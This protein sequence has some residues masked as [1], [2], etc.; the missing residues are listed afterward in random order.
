VRQ[1][2]DDAALVEFERALRGLPN[3]SELMTRIARAHDRLGN[4]DQAYA[5]HQ[6][7]VELDPRNVDAL[8]SL[9]FLSHLFTKRYEDAVRVFD[10]TLS[11][12]PDFHLAAVWRGEAYVRWQGQLEPLRSTLRQLPR[13][14][15]LRTLGS[16]DAHRATLLLWE[17]QADAL[18]AF[19]DTVP[20]EVFDGQ[21]LFFPRSLFAG[22]AHQLR[23]DEPAA[24]LAFE[25]AVASLGPVLT[26][27]PEDWRAHM[28]RGLALAGLGR[29][30]EGLA[31]ARW[32]E[33]SAVYRNDRLFGEWM[34]EHRAMALA[35][36]GETEEALDEIQRLLMEPS[37]VSVHTL[38][39]DPRWDPIR[40]HPRFKALLA[41]YSSPEAL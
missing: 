20:T 29:R 9:G 10:R 3:D 7:A 19:L 34:A 35:R 26:E 38:R 17:R 30:E 32:L 12:A 27:R 31:E 23:R 18:I 22:W 5:A 36:L 6:R 2:D 28:A 39:L 24:R 11:L 14:T 16:A 40:D 21:V 25:S 4:W 37:W 15:Q 1:G 8:F 13:D 41:K 33:Q